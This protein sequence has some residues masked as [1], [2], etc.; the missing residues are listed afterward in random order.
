MPVLTPDQ[1]DTPLDASSMAEAGS[2][3]GSGAV[4]VIDD[5]CCMV[6]LGL[7]VAQFYMHE[8]CGKCTPCREGT[9]WMV[10]IL[11]KI[12]LGQAEQG[13]LDLL[14]DVCDRILGKCLCPLGDAA[15]MPVASYIDKFRDEFQAH[16]D[17]GCPMTA[18]PRSSASSRPSTSTPTRPWQ[19]RSPHERARAGHVTV[20]GR[21]VQVPK[22][23][24]L[25]ESAALAG[26]EIPVFCY[27][28]RLGPAIGACRMCLVELEGVPKLQAGC[29]LTAQDGMVVRTAQTSAKAAEGQNATLEF[30][31]VN[32]PLDCPV[33]D[34]GGECPLQDLTF[35]WGPGQTRMTFPK[36]TL[37]KPIPISPAISLDRE[38]CILCY[39]CTRFSESVSEDGQLVARNRGAL[40]MITT[41]EGEPYS[42]AFT[43]N[44]TELCP[45]GALPPTQYRFQARPW[46]IQNVPTVCGLCPVGCNVS[47]TTREGRAKRVLSRNHP[48]VDQGWLCD[49]GRFSFPHV[50]AE[51]RIREPLLRTRRRGFSPFSWD[52]ALDRAEE[53]IR[54]AEG[55][56]VTALS[57]SETVEQAY[58][59]GKLLRE[60]AG[61]HSAVLPEATS[62]ALDAFRAPLSAIGQAELVVVLGEDAVVDRAPIVD[63]WIRQARRNGAAVELVVDS[64]SLP[65]ELEERLRGCDRAA[66]VWS[67]RAGAAAPA[68]PSSPTPSASRGSPAA[69]RSTSPPR[70]TAAASRRRG[71]SRR[72]AT[73]RTRSRSAYSSSRATRPPPIRLC[74]RSPSSP[75]TSSR[76]RCST[77]SPSGGPTSSCL[78]RATS[79]ATARM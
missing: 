43:G 63:L 20:D 57:G 40:S 65:A 41:F 3:L 45:V 61:A 35:R 72:R 68:S 1:I 51:D 78:G 38:R 16:L 24:G 60:G 7:R 22:G 25:V 79:S 36:R 21:S 23:L 4:I 52:D 18:S 53:L 75:S 42:G 27:E 48:E 19:T 5:R 54:G 26:I 33:C 39:R 46:E 10:Q 8:S 37:E 34:K 55:R 12:E 69:P 11:D 13:D 14:L 30:I 76:S 67:G 66:L 70:P 56:I 17:H 77:A 44:V 59:L 47:V 73:R 50:D 62:S 49:K 29:T 64:H 6:Q 31:L 58:A 9:R 32:H 28:P 2:M 74:A 15:A 71:R